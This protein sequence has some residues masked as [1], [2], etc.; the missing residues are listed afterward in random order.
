MAWQPQPTDLLPEQFHIPRSL[1]IMLE[2]LLGE[3]G[4]L[5][6][7]KTILK[8]SFAQDLVY[9]ITNGRVKTPKSILLPTLIKSL[10]N[11]TEVINYYGDN[12]IAK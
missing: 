6:N 11:N 3:D 12:T 4:Y 7:R 9:A 10:T 5:N 8:H 2:T 1:N